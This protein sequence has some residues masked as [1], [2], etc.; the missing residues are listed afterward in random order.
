M[1]NV[2]I[3]NDNVVNLGQTYGEKLI[4]LTHDAVCHREQINDHSLSNEF[5]ISQAEMGPISMLNYQK[6]INV[7][8]TMLEEQRPGSQCSSVAD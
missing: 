2:K 7:P 1:T 6:L 5:V 4:N 3:N 8:Q